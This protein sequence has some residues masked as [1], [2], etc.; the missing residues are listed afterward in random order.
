MAIHSDLS[1]L[2]LDRSVAEK[3]QAAEVCLR[4]TELIEI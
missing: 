2:K 3:A 4:I 1:T